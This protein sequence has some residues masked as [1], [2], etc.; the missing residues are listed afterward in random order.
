MV[1]PSALAQIPLFRAF[2]DAELQALEALGKRQT[3]EAHSNIII[4]GELTWGI[5]VVLKGQVGVFKSS[6]V[7]QVTYDVARLGAGNFFGEMSL[8]DD[9]P[10]F[11]TVKALVPTE[12]FSIAKQDFTSFLAKAGEAR[13]RFY[14]SCVGHLVTRLREL[15][16]DYVLSQ[17]QLWKSALAKKEVA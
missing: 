2:K 12:I 15:D 16:E 10:R 9:A 1:K 3:Y 8:I 4:E 17:Y 7:G 6:R 5:F 11:A 14:E 13:A